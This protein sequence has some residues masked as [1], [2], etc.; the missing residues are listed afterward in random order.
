MEHKNPW[1]ERLLHYYL[2]IF[3]SDTNN[4]LAQWTVKSASE[5]SLQNWSTGLPTSDLEP[6]RMQ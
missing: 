1:V 6:I 5:I 4:I 3:C 2:F